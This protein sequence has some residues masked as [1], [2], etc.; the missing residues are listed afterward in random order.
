MSDILKNRG[1]AKKSYIKRVYAVTKKVF[2]AEKVLV[3]NVQR[4][5]RYLIY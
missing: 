4:V 2:K 1:S 3:T 5:N